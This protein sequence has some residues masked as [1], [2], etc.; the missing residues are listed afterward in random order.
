M[1]AFDV[2]DTG[3]QVPVLNIDHHA[4]S[5]TP[6]VPMSITISTPDTWVSDAPISNEPTSTLLPLFD[7]QVELLFRGPPSPKQ[8]LQRRFVPCAADAMEAVSARS[9]P[10]SRVTFFIFLPPET[11]S[12]RGIGGKLR[13][14]GSTVQ[15]TRATGSSGMTRPIHTLACRRA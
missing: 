7:R 4:G 6:A 3:R 5:D 1:A 2:N 14:F 12:Q 8:A 10:H 13:R 11:S 15:S 9:M